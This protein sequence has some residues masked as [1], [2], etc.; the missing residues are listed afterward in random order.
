LY[1]RKSSDPEKQARSIPDQLN[2]C[3]NLASRLG[4][5]IVDILRETKSAKK[6]HKKISFLSNVKGYR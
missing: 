5:K 2:E 6:P 3:K 1:A 4:I